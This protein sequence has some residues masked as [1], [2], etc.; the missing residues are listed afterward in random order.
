MPNFFSQ[1]FSA[2]LFDYMIATDDGDHKEKEQ[3]GDG[4]HAVKKKSKRHAKDAE[5][6]VARG[7]D[8][9][10]VHTVRT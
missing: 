8:F 4:D 9:K 1:G 6:G 5:A 7:I 2:G 3:E 10:N